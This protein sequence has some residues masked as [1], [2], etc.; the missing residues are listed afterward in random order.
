MSMDAVSPPPAPGSIVLVRHGE[1]E[2]SLSGRHTSTTDLP[3]TKY[4]MKQAE[5][6]GRYLGRYHFDLVLCSPR[7]RALQTAKFAG[8]E[9]SVTVDPNLAEW[10]YGGYEGLT[11]DEIRADREGWDLW[12]D[13]A[14]R[15]DTAGETPAEVNRRA[16]AILNLIT[17]DVREGNDVL[18]IAHAHILRAIAV[19]WVGLPIAAGKTLTL[20]PATISG[21]GYENGAEAILR[22]NVPPCIF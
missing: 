8:Y 14:P 3:L 4:G 12:R 9:K 10:N 13:G 16:R 1:T 2:W 17:P 18:L 22:W 15:G 20:L 6:V 11:T 21:L 19:R 7:Q 5:E